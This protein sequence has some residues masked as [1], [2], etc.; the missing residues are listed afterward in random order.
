[1]N[2]ILVTQKLYI[3]PE[4]R[5]KKKLYKLQFFISVLVVC[6]LS[7]YYIYA[8]YDRNKSEEVSQQILAE[9]QLQNAQ[10]NTNI[11]VTTEDTTTR[12]VT[13]D[14]IIVAIEDNAE[15]D[16]Q[17]IE[18][19]NKITTQT[20]T[21]SN[22][23]TYTVEAILNIPR[24]SINYPIISETSEELLKISLNKYWGPGPNEVGNYCIVGHNY[25]NKKMFGR[26]NEIVS[27]DTVELT[28]MDGNTL[29]YTVYDKYVV[30]PTDVACTSQLTNGNK[31]V[32]LITC[33]NYGQQRLVVKA[34]ATK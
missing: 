5:R 21:A 30:D 31:E 12:Q 28:D 24:L 11:Q 33:T 32:T 6:L 26:L 1:M 19:T 18:P 8:E 34:R 29:K 14:V 3:T 25:K 22:G 16:N 23:T 10:E 13:D 20:Y 9:V 27:G 17:I 4:L 7:S 15:L 2:Q